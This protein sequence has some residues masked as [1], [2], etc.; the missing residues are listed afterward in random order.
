[1]RVS[2]CECVAVWLSM[3]SSSRELG[4]KD[5]RHV[6]RIS[7]WREKNPCVRISGSKCAQEHSVTGPE[8]GP[9]VFKL[10]KP[11]KAVGE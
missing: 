5:V 10:W 9:S 1:V 2:V 6:G 4:R 8:G 3:S 11:K 7:L